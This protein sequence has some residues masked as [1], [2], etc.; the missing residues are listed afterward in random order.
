MA[1]KNKEDTY[2]EPC[3]EISNKDKD[4]TKSPNL[5]SANQPQPQAPKKD[6]RNCRKGHLATEVNA[7]EVAK[8]D[9]DK[10]PKDLSHMK[11]YT[12]KQKGHYVNKC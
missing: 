12:C 5:S 10:A 7:T 1:K 6:K 8:K 11:C 9:K 2:W 3:N 4:K